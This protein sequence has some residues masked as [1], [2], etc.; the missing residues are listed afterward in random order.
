MLGRDLAT[1]ITRMS[2]FLNYRE[3]NYN[4]PLSNQT[5]RQQ[6]GVFSKALIL[7]HKT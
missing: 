7:T 1:T 6:K 5:N 3:Q 2:C 4:N